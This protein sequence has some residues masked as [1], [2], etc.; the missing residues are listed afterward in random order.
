M[1][2]FFR[3]PFTASDPMKT[4]NIILRGIDQIDFPAH[5][6]KHAIN[7]IKKLCKENSSERLGNQKGGVMDIKNHK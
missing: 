5:I 3:P 1:L 7:L 6:T 4:Y 2:I